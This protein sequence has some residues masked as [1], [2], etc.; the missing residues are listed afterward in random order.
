MWTS[1]VADLGIQVKAA[2][3]AYCKEVRDGNF[4]GMELTLK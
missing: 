1:E 2:V 3:E 4:P